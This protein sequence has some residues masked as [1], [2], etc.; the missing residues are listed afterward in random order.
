MVKPQT[1]TGPRTPFPAPTLRPVPPRARAVTPTPS[2]A[3][4]Q[5]QS[6]L[7]AE[8]IL[9]RIAVLEL[10][11]GYSFTERELAEQLGVGK[12]PVREALLRIAAT[13][14][15]EARTGSG[16]TVAPLT[17]QGA[18]MV[19]QAWRVAEPAAIELSL[20]PGGLA[21]N[22][23]ELRAQLAE[24][25]SPVAHLDELVHHMGFMLISG[26]AYL[27]RAFPHIE[28][29][30]CLALAHVLGHE[31]RC[32]AA[33]HDALLTALETRDDAAVTI[34]R[35]NID[36]LEEQVLDALT[37]ATALQAVNLSRT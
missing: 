33:R 12:V 31:V 30:R 25:P 4:P 6:A 10:A 15:V 19:F 28:A 21:R 24:E 26:N 32:G 27:V 13:G 22:A 16:Y 9:R 35:R 7:A 20:R 3:D 17:L 23:T 2:S 1:A 14:L 29:T 18:R 34:S 5:T 11:P 37:S 8:E 36:A